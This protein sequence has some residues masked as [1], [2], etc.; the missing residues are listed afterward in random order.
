MTS[1]ALRP[2]ASASMTLS[3]VSVPTY[4]L[5]SAHSGRLTDSSTRVATGLDV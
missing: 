2:R 5:G 3:R 4:K 1:A